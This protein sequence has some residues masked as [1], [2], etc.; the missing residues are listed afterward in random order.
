VSPSQAS[1]RT[2]DFD[3][4]NFFIKKAFQFDLNMYQEPKG[5]YN[6][7]GNSIRTLKDWIREEL[8]LPTDLLQIHRRIVRKLP[9]ERS[10]LQQSRTTF[11]IQ[12]CQA[13]GRTQQDYEMGT[14]HN[15]LVTKDHEEPFHDFMFS[16]L[17]GAWI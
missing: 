10:I 2:R 11:Q 16:M 1:Q 12:T 8:I 17:P 14:N 3:E 6:A 4:I 7:K 5:E 15:L 9:R 13:E